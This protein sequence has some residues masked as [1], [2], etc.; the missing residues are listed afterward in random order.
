VAEQIFQQGLCLPSGSSLAEDDRLRVVNLIRKL[1]GR[2]A[3]T[4]GTRRPRR[5]AA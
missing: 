5:K 4:F 1:G 3:V 2:R